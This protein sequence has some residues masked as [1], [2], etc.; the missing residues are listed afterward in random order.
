MKCLLLTLTILNLDDHY[1]AADI[2]ATCKERYDCLD[3][4]ARH[5]LGPIL[6]VEQHALD[7]KLALWYGAGVLA[8]EWKV[9]GLAIADRGLHEL[10]IEL[11][12][13]LANAGLRHV[14]DHALEIPV[15]IGTGVQLH[16]DLEVVVVHVAQK[17][18]RTVDRTIAS[19]CFQIV[20]QDERLRVALKGLQLLIADHVGLLALR[21][22]CLTRYHANFNSLIFT[23]M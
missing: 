18:E 7:I 3:H 16:G 14:E 13:A 11:L 6:G 23:A 8:D 1:K 2:L 10:H 12:E 15:V 20:E 22:E 5:L 19:N 21:K 17:G 9:R 4:A